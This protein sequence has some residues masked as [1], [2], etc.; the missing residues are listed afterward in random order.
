MLP[1][2]KHFKFG[3]WSMRT[4]SQTSKILQ[5]MREMDNYRLEILWAS[6]RG[7][8]QVQIKKHFQ[9]EKKHCI[10]SGRSDKKERAVLIMTE[11]V[12]KNHSSTGNLLTNY[13]KVGFSVILL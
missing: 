3:Y 6:V 11:S 4:M 12:R 9:Q 8:C 5:I 7:D 10:Y 2:R 13:D 1:V